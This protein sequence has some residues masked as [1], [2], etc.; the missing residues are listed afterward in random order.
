M[1]ET[2]Y[3]RNS[4]IYFLI[5]VKPSQI[6]WCPAWS[7][8]GVKKLDTLRQILEISNAIDVNN[9][10][11]SEELFSQSSFEV[12]QSIVQAFTEKVE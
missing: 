6:S 7:R 3:T 2:S 10:D 1:Q 4:F 9:R 11:L 12:F 8:K 5:G